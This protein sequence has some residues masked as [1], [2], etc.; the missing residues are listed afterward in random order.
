MYREKGI[1]RV[2]YGTLT[3]CRLALMKTHYNVDYNV[4]L[5]HMELDFVEKDIDSKIEVNLQSET[6]EL[7]SFNRWW[8]ET[9]PFCNLKKGGKGKVYV[10]QCKKTKSHGWKN[11][12]V[13]ST[14][15]DLDVRYDEH[16]NPHDYVD[17]TP[18]TA[19]KHHHT[20]NA[21]IGL[22]YDLMTKYYDETEEIGFKNETH[23]R[24][25][26]NNLSKELHAAKFKVWGDWGMAKKKNSKSK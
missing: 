4:E 2:S 3:E 15:K 7:V 9:W 22:R 8:K 20:E 14:W 10:I 1:E 5:P 26:E 13:G 12:Y 16:I 6:E 21:V 17:V 23:L 19:T 24:M 11:V 25:A 18:T